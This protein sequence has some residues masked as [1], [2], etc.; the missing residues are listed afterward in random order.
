MKNNVVTSRCESIFPETNILLKTG[1]LS[2]YAKICM[3]S[4]VVSCNFCKDFL[5]I[6]FDL[7]QLVNNRL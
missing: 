6:K 2:S 3:K 5:P 1:K 7:H 4:Y